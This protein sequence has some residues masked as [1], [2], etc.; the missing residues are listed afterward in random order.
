MTY[1]Q[2]KSARDAIK[3]RMDHYAGILKDA[4]RG[5]MGLTPDSAKTPEWRAAKFGFAQ[6]FAAYRS[7]NSMM[8][9]KF[10]REMA[11]E[12]AARRSPAHT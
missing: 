5:P 10:K 6:A 1:E 7:H 9:Q 11:I 8:A 4:P 3:A 12:R 2:A